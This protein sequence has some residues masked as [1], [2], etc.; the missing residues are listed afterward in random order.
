MTHK[1][2]EKWYLIQFKP[3]CDRLAERNL[4]RQ[5]FKTFLPLQEIGFRRS[6]GLSSVVKPLFPGY[7]FVS[8]DPSQG[9]WRKI[10][11]T[12][13]V[14]RL[15]SFNKIPDTVPLDFV[16]GLKQRCD[17]AGKLLPPE[18]LE[19]GDMVKILSGPFANFIATIDKIDVHRRISMLIELMGQT[20]R[21]SVKS[22]YIQ[23]M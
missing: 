20:T 12:L 3:N 7:M 22:N 2:D 17:Q 18:S 19:K 11:S 15:V 6:S 23:P 5:G 8:F 9:L 21:I 4:K 13:G 14:S 1:T 10:N 16:Q